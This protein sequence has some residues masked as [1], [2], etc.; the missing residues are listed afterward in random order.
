MHGRR[1]SASALVRIRSLR[2][3]SLKE[4]EGVAKETGPSEGSDPFRC[5]GRREAAGLAE[6]FCRL[7]PQGT[8]DTERGQPDESQAARLRR[9]RYLCSYDL[10]EEPGDI[11][12]VLLR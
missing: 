8:R 5:G 9:G 12:V 4:R 6:L 2:P 3:L 11:G 10:C 1:S 7:T